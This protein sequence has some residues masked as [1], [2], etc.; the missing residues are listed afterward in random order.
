VLVE[1]P[2][3]QHVAAMREMVD[4]PPEDLGRRFDPIERDQFLRFLPPGA[5]T[6][7]LVMQKDPRRAVDLVGRA[8]RQVFEEAERGVW[9]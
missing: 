2:Q 4:L 8:D 6:L 7:V 3:P 9:Q 5:R 1:Q